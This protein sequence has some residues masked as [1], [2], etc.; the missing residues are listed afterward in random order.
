MSN[1]LDNNTVA[2]LDSEAL[3][4]IAITRLQNEYAD[5]VSRQAWDELIELFTRRLPVGSILIQ[6]ARSTIPAPGRSARL[7]PA[8]PRVRVL[9]VRHS[10]RDR[11]RTR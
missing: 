3:A 10:Q 9:P 1:G 6:S 4:Y 5:A 7:S 2:N 11:P 8:R